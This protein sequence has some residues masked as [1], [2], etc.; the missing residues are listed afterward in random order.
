MDNLIFYG[1][2]TS[3]EPCPYLVHKPQ[4]VTMAYVPMQCMENLYQPE[5][6]LDRGTVFPDLDKPWG[7]C[8]HER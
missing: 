8:G 2:D 4:V 3:A 1:V 5:E 7:G 6:G